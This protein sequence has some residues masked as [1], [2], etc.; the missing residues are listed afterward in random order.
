MSDTAL[1]YRSATATTA[2]VVL[3]YAIYPYM[4]LMRSVAGGARG[5][6]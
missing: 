6:G 4:K 5:G 2:R 3:H 1:S